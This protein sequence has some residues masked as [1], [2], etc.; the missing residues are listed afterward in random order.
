MEPGGQGW[1]HRESLLETFILPNFYYRIRLLLES[2]DGERER[3][4]GGRERRG[5]RERGK[6]TY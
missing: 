2:C 4:R 3:E 6:H 5:E 1:K